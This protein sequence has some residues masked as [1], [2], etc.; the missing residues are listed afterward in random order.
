MDAEMKPISRRTFLKLAAA[1][2]MVLSVSG[3]SLLTPSP[4]HQVSSVCSGTGTPPDTEFDYIVIGSGAGGGPV[5]ANLAEAGYTVLLLEA[6]GEAENAHYSV[7]AFHPLSTEDQD[8]QWNYFIRHYA[9]DGRQNND[10]KRDKAGKGIWYPRA[11]T[12]GGCTAH[13]AMITVYPHQSDWDRIAI[14]TGDDSWSSDKMRKYF[15]LVERC[16]YSSRTWD[17]VTGGRHGFSGWLPTERPRQET[18]EEFVKKDPQLQH[19]LA[20]VALT[21]LEDLPGSVPDAIL[22][23]AIPKLFSAALKEDINHMDSIKHRPEGLYLTP[24]A[25]NGGRRA[26]VR[27]RIRDVKKNCPSQLV[28]KTNVLVTK[29]LLEKVSAL[30]GEQSKAIGV[31]C[32]EGAHLYRADPKAAADTPSGKQ[33]RAKREVIL[34]AG[35]FNTPQLLMLSGIGSREELERHSIPVL[36]EL[37]GVGKNLQDRYEVGIVYKLKENLS[38]LANANFMAD[39]QKD[40]VY[41]EWNEASPEERQQGKGFL[42]SSNGVIIAVLKRSSIAKSANQPPDLF[43]FGLPSDFRGYEQGYTK[44]ITI[45]DHFTWLVLKAHTRNT[46]GE[47]TLRSNDARDTPQINF[48]YFEEGNDPNKGRED[49]DAMVEAIAFIRKIMNRLTAEGQAEEIWPGPNVSDNALR[50]WIMNEAWGHHASCSCKLGAEGD[51]L[52]VL[53]NNFRVRGTTNLRVV[54]ASVFPYIP[55]FFIVTPVYM[56]AEKAS[57]VILAEAKKVSV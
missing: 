52:A 17:F 20:A 34:S 27:D 9:N 56:I 13:N 29:I 19:I 4:T 40:P 46:G 57:E 2:G 55:G 54:D 41:R 1:T 49:L 16:Q 47:V 37:P 8:L 38:T 44:S 11:G 33:F 23:R 14:L 28:V 7:P 43:I 21:T 3:C 10:T 53:D 31:E 22:H 50:E 51:G 45:K 25:T 12:L 32:R 35:A 24:L 30:K 36:I 15:Q 26:S 39:E 18:L 42:Y 6:G 48:K 5:A